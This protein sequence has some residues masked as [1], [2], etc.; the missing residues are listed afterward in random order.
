MPPR[1]PRW[2][3][4][5]AS[6]SAVS[7]PSFVGSVNLRG[8]DLGITAPRSFVAAEVEAER[9]LGEVAARHELDRPRAVHGGRVRLVVRLACAGRRARES[10]T[11]QV[12]DWTPSQ[13]GCR[14]STVQWSAVLS[15]TR[16]VSGP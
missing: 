11:V 4:P 13:P 16:I 10:L 8:C 15:A 5:G 7:M 2:T 12:N 6:S 3:P 1:S 9:H 14:H